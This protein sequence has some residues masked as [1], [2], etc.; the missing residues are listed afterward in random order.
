[1]AIKFTATAWRDWLESFARTAKRAH[2]VT[3]AGTEF[4][5]AGYAPF[6][7]LGAQW[8]VTERGTLLVAS[9]PELTWTFTGEA[10]VTVAGYQVTNA[11]KA[12]LWAET[13]GQEPFAVKRAGDTLAVTMVVD[14][15]LEAD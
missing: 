1:M 4:A 7:L 2:L 13:F 6:A 15:D 14:L 9:Y 8:T 11:A 3:P 5:G 12:V 10:A